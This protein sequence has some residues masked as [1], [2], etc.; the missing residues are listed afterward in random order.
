MKAGHPTAEALEQM[1]QQYDRQQIQAHST[2]FAVLE[3]MWLELARALAAQGALN[4]EA[5]A[6]QLEAHAMRAPEHGD[7]CFGLLS[8]ARRL[9]QASGDPDSLVQ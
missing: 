3:Q 5:L 4:A 2:Q 9:R 1:R 7:W 6:Q 8:I